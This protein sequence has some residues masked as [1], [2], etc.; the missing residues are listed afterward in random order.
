MGRPQVG[1]V[2]DLDLAQNEAIGAGPRRHQ[3]D[4][5][6]PVCLIVRATQRLD[7]QR[8]PS[9]GNPVATAC[10]RRRKHARKDRGSK[11]AKI[12][13]NVSCAGLPLG[14]SR[15]LANQFC[16]VS[17]HSAMSSQLS[18]PQITA[19]SAITTIDSRGWSLVSSP[20]GSASAAKCLVSAT[21]GEGPTISPLQTNQ[22]RPSLTSPARTFHLDA[23]ALVRRLTML[24]HPLS[25]LQ[26]TRNN[27][28][29]G[30][31]GRQTSKS[32]QGSIH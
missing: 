3:V 18:A 8:D 7:I 17:P 30:L 10:I 27:T 2:V 28:V 15:K 9:V 5:R 4:R 25:H 19:H 13:L 26:R 1:L 24:A 16:F 29:F 21:T 6:F 23:L 12:R 22:S 31:V 32:P 14:R 20:R 11:A